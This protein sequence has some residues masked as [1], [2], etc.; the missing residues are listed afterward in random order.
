MEIRAL[1]NQADLWEPT[2]RFAADSSWKAGKYLAKAMEENQ[3]NDWERVFVALVDQSLAGFCTLT[4]E[5]G[6]PDLD[7]GPY[8][9]YVFVAEA[10]RGKRISEQLCLSAI[11][12]ANQIGYSSVYLISDHINLYEKYGFS[13]IAEKQAPWGSLESIYHYPIR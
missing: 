6:I 4:Q 12:Y 8:I 3:F 2:I 13:K 1:T 9:G 5:D 7:Y 11:E 10:Y